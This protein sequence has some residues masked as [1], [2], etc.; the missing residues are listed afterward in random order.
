MPG[1]ADVVLAQLLRK[2]S[3]DAQLSMRL[4]SQLFCTRITTALSDDRL[5]RLVRFE[6]M[7]RMPVALTSLSDE[8]QFVFALCRR[9]GVDNRN[10]GLRINLPGF[11]PFL[12][13]G[14][15]SVARAAQFGGCVAIELLISGAYFG[16][17]WHSGDSI[18][19]PLVLVLEPLLSHVTALSIH[20]R[21][22]G[23][24]LLL[25]L[26]ALQTL[27]MSCSSLGSP[28]TAQAQALAPALA[29]LSSLTSLNLFSNGLGNDAAVALAPALG[30]LTALRSL[31]LGMNAFEGAAGVAPLLP[32]L[33]ALT[34]L[35]SLGLA[36]YDNDGEAIAALAPVLKTLT[37]LK[38]LALGVH[39]F[40]ASS[41]SASEF[42]TS[43]DKYAAAAFAQDAWESDDGWDSDATLPAQ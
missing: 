32:A 16:D 2:M 6:R 34:A 24:P 8:A 35:T 43:V 40:D 27:D 37:G 39:V 26:P 13:Y 22:D 28:G 38:R 30:R 5:R 33:T 21:A 11:L 10:W 36:Q 1:L 3:R 17:G 14:Q 7:F 4:L 25:R 12:A 42:W 41:S 31:D 19:P 18:A 20:N 15:Q 29:T 23:L 9:F